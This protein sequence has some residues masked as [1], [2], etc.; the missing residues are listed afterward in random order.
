MAA[1]PKLKLLINGT[2]RKGSGGASEPVLNPATEEP[3]GEVPHASTADLDEALAAAGH[4][5]AVWRTTPP[6]ERSRIICA[7]A[8]LVR[9]GLEEIATA[10]TL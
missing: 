3:L 2:W 6:H 8:A 5:F 9:E 4:G 10:L 1:Y 7:A